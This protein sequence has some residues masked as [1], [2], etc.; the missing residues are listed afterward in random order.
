ML[1]RHFLLCV[2]S[3]CTN[4]SVAQVHT[5]RLKKHGRTVQVFT[6]NSRF[7]FQTKDGSWNDGIIDHLSPDTLYLTRTVLNYSL[8][9]IDTQHFSGYRYAIDEIN[10]LPSRREKV[11]NNGGRVKVILGHEK[12][13][14]IRNG[15]FFNLIGGGYALLN[16]TNSVIDKD[17]PFS[18]KNISR[19]ALAGAAFLGGHILKF[20]FNS[21][22]KIGKKYQLEISDY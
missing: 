4:A 1:T 11:I 2:F 8:G 21:H 15:T 20:N 9:G 3:I 13:A 12:F 10:A 14:W 6:E 22:R 18:R 5:L 7:T 16:I 19:L 17:P